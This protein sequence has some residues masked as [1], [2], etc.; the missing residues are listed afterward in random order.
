MSESSSTPKFLNRELSWLEFNQ[1]VLD[2][3]MNESLPLL[4]RLKFL[5]ITD[6]N[7]DEFFMVRVGGLQMLRKRRHTKRD[8]AGLTVVQ[9]LKAVS[10]RVHQLVADQCSCFLDQLE[11]A[12]AEA[13]IQRAAPGRLTEHQQT[14]VL[15]IF[16]SEVFPVYT[17]M[18]VHAD[19][20]FPLLINKSLNMCVRLAPGEDGETPRFA[21]VPF[22]SFPTRMFR[23]PADEGYQYILLEDLVS[24]FIDRFFPGETVLEAVPF[25]LTR[26]ADLSVR[27]DQAADLMA[28]MEEI[29]DARRESDC[30]RLEVAESCSRPTLAFLKAAL[31]VGGDDVFPARW[32]CPLGCRSAASRGSTI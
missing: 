5:A 20:E 9:Q 10:E 3:A 28:G 4:E 11:P 1:R 21:I 15:K 14:V 24:L 16:D 29:L 27:E 31:G 17:P 2:E 25:R 32:I 7:L 12:L 26:N 30:V 8:P 13:G 18:A 19:A 22:G 23:L 6:S